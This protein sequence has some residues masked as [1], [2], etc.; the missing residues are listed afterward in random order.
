M[1]QKLSNRPTENPYE[2]LSLDHLFEIRSGLKA[3]IKDVNKLIKNVESVIESKVQEAVEWKRSRYEKETG[4]VEVEV[5]GVVV[6]HDVPKRVEWLQR[7]LA[8]VGDKLGAMGHDPHDI[9]VT[10]LSVNENVYKNLP[11][12]VRW[13]LNEARVVK[14]G[15]TTIELKEVIE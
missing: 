14:H 12:K 8:E 6:T 4:R 7:E 1:D 2:N 3:E 10:K 5:E 9:I 11:E 15:K 13:L